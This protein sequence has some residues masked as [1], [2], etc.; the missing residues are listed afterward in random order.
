MVKKTAKKNRF[1]KWRKSIAS[2]IKRT[3][4]GLKR[5]VRLAWKMAKTAEQS[6]RDV[7][8]AIS[9]AAHQ[10]SP[11]ERAQERVLEKA[12]DSFER[13]TSED[14]RMR[15]TQNLVPPP[16]RPKEASECND[17]IRAEQLARQAQRTAATSAQ[18][19]A[20][21]RRGSEGVKAHSRKL[22]PKQKEQA[23][24]DQILRQKQ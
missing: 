3:G 5:G 1:T 14:A 8:A 21:V 12:M 2:T 6:V 20:H 7:T 11:S 22:T 24:N 23:L 10:G 18:V 4:R 17:Q 16:L 15:G 9:R 19:S 13:Q